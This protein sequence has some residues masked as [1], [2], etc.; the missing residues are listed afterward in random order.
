MQAFQKALNHTAMFLALAASGCGDTNKPTQQ[1]MSNTTQTCKGNQD[2]WYC[3]I[4]PGLNVAPTDEFYDTDLIRCVGSKVTEVKGCMT[5]CTVKPSGINDVCAAEVSSTCKGN[6]DGW[7]CYINPSLNVDPNDEFYDT[8]LIHCANGQAVESKLCS[9]GCTVKQAGLNDICTPQQAATTCKGNQD[10][11]YCSTNPALVI[12]PNDEFYDGDL[13]HC[14][15][16]VS[17]EV[18]AC[19]N[20]CIIK[21]SGTNDVC[22]GAVCGNSVIEGSEQCDASNMNGH[23]CMTEGFDGGNVSCTG[24]CTVNTASCCKHACTGNTQC[25]GT[26]QQTCQDSN[27]DGCKEW[28]NTGT[29]P[30]NPVCGNSVIEGSEQCDASNMNGH[31]C[32]TEGFDGGNVSCTGS[33]T[34]NTTSCCK[35]A[36]TGNT[37][38]I[39]TTQQTCQDSNNDGCK[40]WVNTGTC[41]PTCTTVIASNKCFTAWTVAS[42]TYQIFEICAESMGGDAIR[43]HVRKSPLGSFGTRP[44]GLKVFGLSD[45]ECSHTMTYN[46]PTGGVSVNG[47]GTNEL[48][49]DFNVV[50]AAGQTSKRYCAYASTVSSDPGYSSTDPQQK[51]WWYSDDLRLDR[52][53][54]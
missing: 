48:T 47:I 33:C 8:D 28:V 40:E 13:I 43:I 20:D 16:G 26:T 1:V 49:M 41:A 54:N 51:V 10:G 45:P 21:P 17:T 7:Y 38:C 37:Q 25:I 9:Y 31:T 46:D 22:G 30:S 32:M 44:Y 15:G 52:Q 4:N 5:A 35:H 42:G 14:V 34:V 12:G 23:T 6:Q 36:C 11:W 50:W 27:N 18:I 24:S 39:G 29:C 53:C 3:Y 2:G 19:G